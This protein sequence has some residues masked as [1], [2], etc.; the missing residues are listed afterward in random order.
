MLCHKAMTKNAFHSADF[1][2]PVMT[3]NE[4]DSGHRIS[5]IIIVVGIQKFA[6]LQHLEQ[7]LTVT[8]TFVQATFLLG[9]FV[10][11]RISQL[12]LTPF[13]RTFKDRFL[14]PSLTDAHCT[15]TFALAIFDMTTYWPNFDRSFCPKIVWTFI[16]VEQHFHWTTHL[17]T[18]FSYQQFV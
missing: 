18:H 7:I 13:W 8:V 4:S 3:E 10:H 15:V 1:Q 6:S 17:L 12:P 2:Q 5:L 11:I 9:S 14:R 16:F